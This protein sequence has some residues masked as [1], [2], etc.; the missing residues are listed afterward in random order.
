ME[1]CEMYIPSDSC[2]VRL[3]VEVWESGLV[4]GDSN[5][6]RR[7]DATAVGSV[8][9]YHLQVP[10]VVPGRR[11][12][13]LTSQY[14][15]GDVIGAELICAVPMAGLSCLLNQMRGGMAR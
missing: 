11:D 15:W 4:L 3:N 12:S 9:E 8:R 13:L 1:F 2:L 5:H 7:S 6:C 10:R 14:L